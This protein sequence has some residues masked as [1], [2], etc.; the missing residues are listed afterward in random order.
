[1]E[2]T[3]CLFCRIVAGEIPAKKVAETDECLAFR[4]N[5]PKAPTHVLVIPKRHVRSLATADDAALLGRV[6][7]LAAEVAR[8]EG[9]EEEGYRTVLNTNAGSGQTVWHL[10]A[11]VLGGRRMTWP[12]G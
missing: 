7:L 8:S 2:D 10:H 1:M 4:D 12:P 11:H 5:D 9:V 6:L 3:S